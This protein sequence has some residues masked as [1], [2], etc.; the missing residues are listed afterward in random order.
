M[1][2]LPVFLN[3]R[4]SNDEQ[5]NKMSGVF[6]N[7][8]K[9]STGSTISYVSLCPHH[10]H[11]GTTTYDRD[12]KPMYTR[13]L[14]ILRSVPPVFLFFI[15]LVFCFSIQLQ[16]LLLCTIKLSSQTTALARYSGV[17]EWSTKGGGGCTYPYPINIKEP[18][19]EESRVEREIALR[20]SQT[21]HEFEDSAPWCCRILRVWRFS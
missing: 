6:S 1:A 21:Y 11:G 4:A 5:C 2:T 12:S 13:W 14:T 10:D 16:Q 15:L 3:Y 7:A 20:R 18:C 9:Y 19:V 17:R 8:Q